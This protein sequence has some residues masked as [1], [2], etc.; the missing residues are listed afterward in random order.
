MKGLSS[1]EEVGVVV[2]DE[3]CC[4]PSTI[5]LRDAGVDA[6]G[7]FP[8]LFLGVGFFY[9][10]NSITNTMFTPLSLSHSTL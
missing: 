1:E 9:R 10:E 4:W 6:L 5:V 3:G 2:R 8:L 7:D